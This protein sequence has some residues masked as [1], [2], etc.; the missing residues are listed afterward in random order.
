MHKKTIAFVFGTRP[1]LIK[2]VPL[3]FEARKR[4]EVRTVVCSTGQHKDMLDSLYNFFKFAPDIDFQLMKPNQSLAGLHAETMQAMSRVI[5]DERPDWVVVQGDTTSAHAAAMTAFYQKIPVAHVEAGLRTYDIHS[6]FPEE[7][8]RRAIGLVAKVHFCPTEDAAL[9][10]KGEM[11]DPSSLIEKTGNTGIDTLKIVADLVESNPLLKKNFSEQFSFLKNE[12]FILATVHRRENFG[13]SQQQILQAFLKIVKKYKINILF[14]VHPNP[15]VRQ[16]VDDIFKD[17][18]GKSVF[19][20]YQ[21]TDIK[22]EGGKIFLTD[23]LDYPALVHCMEK[24]EFLM[25]DSGGLQEE[26]PSFGKKILV[27]RA[28]TERPE[29]VEAGFSKLVGTDT[30]VILKEADLLLQQ[31]NWNGAIPVNPFGDGKASV[32]IID[33]LIRL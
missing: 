12:K 3:I 13:K 33:T 18:V 14:P 1:E 27:L 28:S 9:N 21:K 2:M 20:T 19:W 11:T 8:N 15:N 16:S 6:P 10:L 31:N 29:G 7:M 4:S 17:E 30:E 22:T 5:A 25:T 32:R 24:C 26:A 23:P